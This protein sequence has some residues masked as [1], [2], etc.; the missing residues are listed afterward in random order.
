MLHA[1]AEAECGMLIVTNIK[2]GV[3]IVHYCATHHS[4]CHWPLVGIRHLHIKV[5]QK[6]EVTLRGFGSL[7][8]GF[9]ISGVFL[10]TSQ[11]KTNLNHVIP[12]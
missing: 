4:I 9:G 10:E 2:R 11:I 5:H 8:T 7:Q 1:E 12:I 3:W 6:S